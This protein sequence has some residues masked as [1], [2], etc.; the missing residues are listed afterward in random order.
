MNYS[1]N[2]VAGKER[3][4]TFYEFQQI[5]MKLCKEQNV[6]CID[7]IDYF[8]AKGSWV[9]NIEPQSFVNDY[10]IDVVSETTFG[11][12]EGIYSHF[13][14]WMRG[15]EFDFAV[16]KNLSSTDETFLNMSIFAAKFCLLARN[17][18]W[19]HEQEF[20]WSGYDVGYEDESGKFVVLMI[21]GRKESAESYARE[22]KNQGLKAIIRD[23]STK[24][25][26]IFS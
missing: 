8:S 3:P 4:Y 12:C 1:K 18:T 21:C 5:I 13:Y 11:S 20:N 19:E 23:N 16:A 25:E 6:P 22:Y 7:D 26:T 17:Y 9:S 24:K 15:K 14:I 2:K 10:D